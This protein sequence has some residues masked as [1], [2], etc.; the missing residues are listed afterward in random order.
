MNKKGFTLV[1][2]LG[3]IIILSLIILLA[4][5]NI[6]NSVKSSSSKTDELTT[7]IIY[8]ATDL[9]IERHSNIFPKTNGNQYT[10]TF[11][12]LIEDELLKEPIKLF[13]S[14]ITNTKCIQVTYNNGF[15]YEL[16][17]IE[18]CISSE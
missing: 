2:L 10:I 1:E 8:E 14:D 3:V 9:Y 12:D 11:S 7:K 18:S 17:D 16:K 13:D 6:V 4:L 15:N 5:P